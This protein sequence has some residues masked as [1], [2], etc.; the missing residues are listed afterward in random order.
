[1]NIL[2]IQP[3]IND[4]AAHD[5]WLQPY[6]FLVILT[7]LKNKGVN[8]Q[9]IDC[10]KT[11]V[12]QD[13]FGKGKY[14]SEEIIKPDILKTIPRYYK[15]YGISIDD[16]IKEFKLT[17][18]DFIL[19]TSSMTYWYPGIADTIKII[20]SIN[21]NIPI[22]VGGTYATLCHEH[23]KANINC[24]KIFQNHEI[25]N[26]FDYLNIKFDAREFYSTLPDYKFFNYKKEYVVIRTSWGCPFN[27]SYCS[28]KKTFPD[29]FRINTDYV[30]DYI[31][32]YY[33]QGIR[34]FVLYDDAFLYENSEVKKLLKKIIDA[35]IN[36]RF[37]TPNALHLRYIDLEI[38][39]LLKQTNFIDPH[40]GLETMEEDLQKTWGGKVNIEDLKKGINFLKQAGFKEGE[41]S[42]YLLF[43]YPGQNLE[44]LKKDVDI[45]NNLGMRVSLSEFSPV[46]GTD[47]FK[48]FENDLKDPLTHNNSIFGFFTPQNMKHL[49]EIKNEIK[50]S[51]KKRF[52]ALKKTI[53]L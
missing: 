6:G 22:I 49:W 52:G 20:K 23:A 43:G 8:T 34:N 42:A 18:P 35:K 33:N 9:Y 25:S 38:A 53:K 32:D 51:Q 3:W 45:L 2:G 30:F 29:F 19:L 37:H 36:I 1:M 48:Q 12:S 39:Q 47:I 41:F 44:Q 14:H 27:C 28:I 4:F 31:L 46:P 11:T 5:F 26:F 40:F 13:E 7:Y 17:N 50:Q 21:S 10:L 15:R 16:F 24:E